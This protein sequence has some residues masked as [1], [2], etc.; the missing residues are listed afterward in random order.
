VT[1][2]VLDTLTEAAVGAAG[3]S[4]GWLLRVEGGELRVVAAAGERPGDAIGLAVPL[5]RG[6]AGFVVSSGQPLAAMPR[7]GDERFAVGVAVALG[8]DTRAVLCVPCGTDDAVLGA[9]EVVDKPGGGPFSIDDVE[10]LT[11]LGTIAGAAL[12][13]GDDAAG[14]VPGPDE[15]AAELRRLAA[16]DPSRYAFVAAA[17][18]ALL[19]HG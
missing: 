9:L 8:I 13:G 19:A 2:A 10:L 11:L 1:Q 18:D 14:A 15:L 5:D 3:A 7:P 17:V 16:A 6:T 12:A 4:R